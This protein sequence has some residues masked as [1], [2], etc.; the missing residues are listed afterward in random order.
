MMPTTDPRR[1]SSPLPCSEG[2]YGTFDSVASGARIHRIPPCR[3]D[4][5]LLSWQAVGQD[6]DRQCQK[7]LIH[8][9]SLNRPMTIKSQETKVNSHR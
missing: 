2:F 9:P 8:G 4:W 3:S 7:N 1:P 5:T 6:H